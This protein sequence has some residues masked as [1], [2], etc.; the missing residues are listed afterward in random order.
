[1]RRSHFPNSKIQKFNSRPQETREGKESKVRTST[2]TPIVVSCQLGGGRSTLASILLVLI[3]QW[4]ESQ[5]VAPSAPGPVSG[6]EIAPPMKQR[7]RTSYQVIN[8]EFFF[9]NDDVLCN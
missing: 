2:N 9:S 5:V 8:S 1:M 7:P 6:G 3:R 4:L